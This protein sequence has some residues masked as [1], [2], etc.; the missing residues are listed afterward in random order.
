MQD[1]ASA[2]IV[3]GDLVQLTIPTGMMGAGKATTG[4]IA[5]Q[6]LPDANLVKADV[7]YQLVPDA[8]PVSGTTPVQ[9]VWDRAWIASTSLTKVVSY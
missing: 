1:S 3:V 7:V 2:A 9:P 6:Q 5:R 8:T 4:M